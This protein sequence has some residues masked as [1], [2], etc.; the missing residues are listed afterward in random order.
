M[1]KNK[2]K[3]KKKIIQ[4]AKREYKKSGIVPLARKIDNELNASLLQLLS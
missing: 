1:K 3:I 2:E 4:F